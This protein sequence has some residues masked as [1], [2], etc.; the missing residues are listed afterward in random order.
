MKLIWSDCE[1]DKPT[2]TAFVFHAQEQASL[3]MGNR[4]H[5]SHYWRDGTQ[6]CTDGDDDLMAAMDWPRLEQV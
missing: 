5:V 2:I 4:N 3:S 6:M 1:I